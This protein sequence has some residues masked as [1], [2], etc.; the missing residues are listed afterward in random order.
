MPKGGNS[1][2]PSSSSSGKQ[3]GAPAERGRPLHRGPA[4]TNYDSDPSDM[5]SE[6]GL[7][8]TPLV[9]VLFAYLED[10]KL[11][12]PSSPRAWLDTLIALLRTGVSA[13]AEEVLA[14][15]RLSQEFPEALSAM[16]AGFETRAG[17]E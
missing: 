1:S 2:G 13:D 3:Q 10:K 14:L 16:L 8:N 9:E 6:D 4:P 5:S 7:D 17:R 12:A 15:A 11:A